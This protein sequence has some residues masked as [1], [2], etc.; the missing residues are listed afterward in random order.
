MKKLVFLIPKWMY[1]FTKTLNC[2]DMKIRSLFVLMFIIPSLSFGQENVSIVDEEEREKLKGSLGSRHDE[3][4]PDSVWQVGGT[5]GLNFSQSYFSNWA[6][7]GQ[8]A[9]S[10]TALTSLFAKYNKGGHY[11]ETTLDMAYGQLSQDNRSPIK[12]DDR[13]D[14]TSKYGIQ[15]KNDHWYYSFLFNFRTQFIEGFEIEDGR[16]VGPKISDFLAPAFSILSFGADYRPSD[17]FSAFISPATTK[18]TIVTED[19]LVENFGVDAGENVRFEL[20]AFVKVAFQD[21]IFEN[22]NL[23]TRAD[24]FSNYLENPQNVDVNWETLITFKVNKWLAST[25]TTQLIYDDDIIVGQVTDADTGAIIETGGPRTQ[26][27]QVFSLGLSA[28]F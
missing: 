10:F 18:I 6:A 16:E 22:V 20:G 26:F 24:F 8:N 28:R 14:L 9:V 25:L 13:F 4:H 7:G 1:I 12:T 23:L 3:A 19:E 21:D 17:K 11:W 2:I 5:A 27:R 15:A